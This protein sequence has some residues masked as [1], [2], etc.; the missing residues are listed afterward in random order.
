MLVSWSFL[1]FRGK[2]WIVIYKL[3]HI[4]LNELN[5]QNVIN[6]PL[7]SHIVL[8]GASMHKK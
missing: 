2:E 5:V 3:I 4:E 8:I 6:C 1:A 7:H